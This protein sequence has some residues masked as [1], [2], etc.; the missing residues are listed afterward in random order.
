MAC[1][2]SV[3]HSWPSFACL[4]SYLSA[5]INKFVA[6]QMG[7]NR[8][9]QYIET[10]KIISILKNICIMSRNW[11]NR[12]DIQNQSTCRIFCDPPVNCLGI[13]MMDFPASYVSLPKRRSKNIAFT[14]PETNIATENRPSQKEGSLPT[15]NFPRIPEFQGGYSP[16]KNYINCPLKNSG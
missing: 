5:S 7:Y 1:R 9:A 4:A 11:Q 16:A 8:N 14:L 13:Q 6:D 12:F 15:T 10:S 3:I 2:S